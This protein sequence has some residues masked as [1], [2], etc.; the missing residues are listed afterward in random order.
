MK[1]RFYVDVPPG[2][3]LE[4]I[5][6]CGLTAWTKPM[7]NI[8]TDYTRVAFDVDLPPHLLREFDHQA[9]AVVAGVIAAEAA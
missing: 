4:L 5:R 3:S 7:A 2:C 1:V 9:P 6:Q 8:C